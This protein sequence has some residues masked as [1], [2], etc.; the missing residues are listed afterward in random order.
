MSLHPDT[1]PAPTLGPCFAGYTAIITLLMN[2]LDKVGHNVH[3]C[4]VPCEVSPQNWD[5][6]KSTIMR[7]REEVEGCNG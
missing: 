4:E 7:G 5:V 2:T 3:T 6:S 1:M